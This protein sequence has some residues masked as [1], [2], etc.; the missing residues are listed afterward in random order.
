MNKLAVLLF[1][2]LLLALG[3]K[4]RKVVTAPPKVENRDTVIAMATA[5]NL[6]SFTLK[7]WKYFSAKIN[8]N[9]QSG[10]NNND[11]TVHVRM[12]KDSLVW[13]SAGLVGIEGARILINKDSMVFLDKMN[14]KYRVYKKDDMTKVLDVPLSVDQV[15]NL[16]LARPIYAL[17]LYQVLVNN[18]TRLDILYNQEKYATSHSYQKSVFTIDTTAIRDRTSR[19]YAMASYSK[20]S[21]VDGFNFP[22]S[23]EI[24]ASNG[25]SMVQIKMDFEDVD[26]VKELT[27]PFAIPASYEKAK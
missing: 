21:V 14:R 18:E 11:V 24:K 4:S 23:A 9:F 19:N 12:L 6:L 8:V 3:C 10:D 22:L 15:Q 7:D 17:K 5:E 13:L 26:F 1:S 2:G 20:Y 27:F 16:I 25:V